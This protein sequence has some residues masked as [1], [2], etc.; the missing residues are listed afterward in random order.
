MCD[1][2]IE[3]FDDTRAQDIESPCNTPQSA[4]F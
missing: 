2:P 4:G 3:T 1:D